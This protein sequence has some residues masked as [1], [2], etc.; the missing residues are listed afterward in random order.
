MNEQLGTAKLFNC[1]IRDDEELRTECIEVHLNEELHYTTENEQEEPLLRYDEN[2]LW[3][4]LIKQQTWWPLRNHKVK[5]ALDSSAC[6]RL[7]YEDL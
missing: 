4:W 7:R 1:A 3:A 5:L 6:V 2:G